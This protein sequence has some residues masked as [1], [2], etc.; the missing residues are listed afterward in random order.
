MHA[1][2]YQGYHKLPENIRV[3]GCWTHAQRRFDEAL[4]TLPK[5]MQKDSPTVIGECYCSWLFKLEHCNMMALFLKS[6]VSTRIKP[7]VLYKR[8]FDL[9]CCA[10]LSLLRARRCAMQQ[11]GRTYI[12]IDLNNAEEKEMPI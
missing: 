6:A 10:I 7:K 11:N 8:L 1:D 9:C 2:G 5:E 12:A 3:V 4:Q